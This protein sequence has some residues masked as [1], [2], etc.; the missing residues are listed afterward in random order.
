MTLQTQLQPEMLAYVIHVPTD[1]NTVR[2]EP[3]TAA[4][5][6]GLLHPGVVMEVIAGPVYNDGMIFWQVR[7]PALAQPGWTSEAN[8][9][10]GES[11][12]APVMIHGE[13]AGNYLSRLQVGDLVLD[14]S[15]GGVPMI[16]TAGPFCAAGNVIWT[17]AGAQGATS[18]QERTT[19]L[20]LVINF[21]SQPWGRFHV[22]QPGETWSTLAVRFGFGANWQALQAKNPGLVRPQD[23][24]ELGDLLWVEP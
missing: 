21:N 20:P 7:S 1:P 9:V 8:Q 11:Y 23:V 10:K 12:L 15:A 16:V 5:K 24:L 2:A 17:L 6:T 22:V 19:L 18:M 3:D 13:C 4:A 14:R